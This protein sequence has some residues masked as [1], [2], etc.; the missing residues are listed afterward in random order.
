MSAAEMTDIV[1]G[2]SKEGASKHQQG[3]EGKNKNQSLPKVFTCKFTV[4]FDLRIRHIH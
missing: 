1:G 2:T 4:S 3:V